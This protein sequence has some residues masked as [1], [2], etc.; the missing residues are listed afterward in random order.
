M[1]Q[2][3]IKNQDACRLAQELAQMTGQSVTQAVI[4]A[5]RAYI[6]RLHGQEHAGRQGLA[7]RLLDIGRDVAALPDLDPRHPDEILYDA[8]GLPKDGGA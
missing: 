7:D 3:N 4:Q 2:L 6:D 1:Q 5:L 8:H